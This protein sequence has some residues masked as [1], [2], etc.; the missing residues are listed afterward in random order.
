MPMNSQF[1]SLVPKKIGEVSGTFSSLVERP[2]IFLAVFG[3]RVRLRRIFAKLLA[4]AK[5]RFSGLSQPRQCGDD[6]L[7]T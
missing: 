1:S 7:R 4:G 5:Q 2:S 6:V 3:I